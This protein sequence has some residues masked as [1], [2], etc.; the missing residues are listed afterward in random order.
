MG[1]PSST[2]SVDSES[3]MGNRPPEDP[4]DGIAWG[5]VIGGLAAVAIMALS[6]CAGTREEKTVSV[7]KR[8]GTEAGKV[9]NLVITKQEQTQSEVK[10]GVDPQMI[11]SLVQD[12][13]KAA[14]P[15]ADA[16]A[17]MIPKPPP[18]APPKIF[19]MD[20]ETVAGAAGA[21]WTA[22]R[23]VAVYH[24]RRRLQTEKKA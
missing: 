20:P 6:G 8:Q 18:V 1:T 3:P 5:F 19:G 24:K 14:V 9:T 11:A 21:L 15:G 4:I 22:E 13:V 16:I 17:A 23:G 7:E 12:A 2:S 10:A